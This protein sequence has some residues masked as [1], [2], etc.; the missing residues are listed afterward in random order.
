MKD[1]PSAK[2]K[3]LKSEG[4]RFEDSRTTF[5][6]SSRLAHWC[7]GWDGRTPGAG[8]LSSGLPDSGMKAGEGERMGG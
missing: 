6:G 1:A 3:S 4:T 5:E 2:G 8:G 7:D